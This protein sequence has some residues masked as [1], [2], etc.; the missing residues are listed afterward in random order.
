MDTPAQL[1]EKVQREIVEV[2]THGLEAG[3]MTE[4]HAKE[5]AKFVLEMIPENISYPK[6]I[7]VIPKLDDEFKELAQ[8]VVPIMSEYERKVKVTV[9]EQVSELIKS[10]KIDAA[11]ELTK[12][13]I[14]Y[15]QRLT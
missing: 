14:A 9:N 4:E 10:G 3:T 8:V 11:L 13:A 7:E 15:E 6:L 1:R 5:I 12:K 2:I